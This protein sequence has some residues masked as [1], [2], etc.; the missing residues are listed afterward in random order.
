MK[1]HHL[2]KIAKYWWPEVDKDQERERHGR[3]DAL[4]QASDQGD[5]DEEDEE[6]EEN[7]HYEG[8]AFPGIEMPAGK[9]WVEIDDQ[10]D[11]ILENEES[12]IAFGAKSHKKWTK[13]EGQDEAIAFPEIKEKDEEAVANAVRVINQER[14]L[15]EE[16]RVQ[17]DCGVSPR[18]RKKSLSG[19]AH[20]CKVDR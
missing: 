18:H 9:K 10:I 5:Q 12:G 3:D 19:G 17:E 6:D 2:R 7:E 13:T 16:L 1:F 8:C 4:M 11:E 14:I 20:G 15:E